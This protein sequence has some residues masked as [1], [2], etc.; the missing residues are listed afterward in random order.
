MCSGNCEQFAIA[1][2]S[3]PK[4]EEQ[5][6]IRRTSTFWALKHYTISTQLNHNRLYGIGTLICIFQIWEMK[7]NNLPMKTWLKEQGWRQRGFLIAH[8]TAFLTH[9][10]KSSA[11]G[12]R[13][14]GAG[15]SLLSLCPRRN[16]RV[17]GTRIFRNS[18][19]W[20]LL[21][22]SWIQ[23]ITVNKLEFL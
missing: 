4:H 6:E 19:S 16:L 12:R 11:Q 3:R 7:L 14:V 2:G 21:V 8:S 15:Q 13:S 20:T 9:S 17:F 10:R 23:P 22:Q 18:C 1:G 5:W